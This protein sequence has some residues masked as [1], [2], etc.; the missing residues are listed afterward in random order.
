MRRGHLVDDWR[1]AWR[2]FSVQIL[3]VLS[4]IP[5]IYENSDFLRELVEPAVFRYGMAALGA[6]ALIA[7]LVKQGGSDDSR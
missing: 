7:R 1:R 6:L 4:T 3:A 5:I 2:W